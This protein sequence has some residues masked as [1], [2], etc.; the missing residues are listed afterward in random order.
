MLR[1]NCKIGVPE[2]SRRFIQ[3]PA[4]YEVGDILIR[5][6]ARIRD[7]EALAAELK[8]KADAEDAEL[9]E[10]EEASSSD[11]EEGSDDEA[12]HR[13]FFQK[14]P[15]SADYVRKVRVFL[16]GGFTAPVGPPV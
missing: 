13:G 14:P 7:Q 4:R 9:A 10:D 2:R 6:Y 16:L 11:S 12:A 3:F 1:C 15:Y 8:A 5:T